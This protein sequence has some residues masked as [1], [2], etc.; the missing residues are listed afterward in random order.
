MCLAN[1]LQT[2][3]NCSLNVLFIVKSF[4]SF[5]YIS[6]FLFWMIFCIKLINEFKIDYVVLMDLLLSKDLV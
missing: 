6:V 5:P 3:I 1:L 4:I 2:C